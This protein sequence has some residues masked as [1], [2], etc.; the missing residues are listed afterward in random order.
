VKVAGTPGLPAVLLQYDWQE[1]YDQ[2]WFYQATNPDGP[3][4]GPYPNLTNSG[5]YS[6][7]NVEVGTPYWYRIEGVK[8]LARADPIS[9]AVLTSEMVTPSLDP[10]PPEA[11]VL[12]NDGALWTSELDVILSFV[13]YESEGLDPLEVFEDIVQM[14]ISNDPSFDG[15]DWQPF[16][17]A[18]PWHL[19]AERGE[20]AMIYALFRDA[21]DNESIGPEVGMILY[22]YYSIYL[23]LVLKAY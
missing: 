6:D 22:A 14:K 13:P 4:S 9:S 5:V 15:V 21:A 11:N 3:W 7:T 16:E 17:L 10:L 1:D 12:I 20:I 18:V 19:E 2:M 8:E 23:P